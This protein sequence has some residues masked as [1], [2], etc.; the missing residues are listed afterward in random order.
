MSFRVMTYNILDGGTNRES[1]ILNVI[2]TV[3]PDVVILQEVFSD[4]ILKL[5]SHSLGMNY[6]LGTGNKQRKVALLS[7]LP[8]ISF[9]SRHPLFPIW[10]NIVDA[11]IEYEPGKT[12]RIIGVHP[13][14]NLGVIFELW[15]M[16]EAQY[17][18][19]YVQRF[20]NRKLRSTSAYKG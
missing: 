17:I 19:K 5:L 18:I 10:R 4:D 14:A 11:E 2:Q 7:K 16:L 1:H 3:K 9:N 12:A 20:Q 15:R 8:V 6:Y 13:I